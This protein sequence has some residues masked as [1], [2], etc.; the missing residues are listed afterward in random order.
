[1]MVQTEREIQRTVDSVKGQS[2]ILCTIS[3]RES[4]SQ[5]LS[6]FFS[7]KPIRR[8]FCENTKN[9]YSPIFKTIS[10]RNEGVVSEM[11][12]CLVTFLI[13]LCFTLL[14]HSVRW[15]DPL[16]E[17]QFRG[18]LKTGT[19]TLHLISLQTSFYIKPLPGL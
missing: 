6:I 17:G 8:M 19:N 5:H 15:S 7:L 2:H 13:L 4:V 10:N 9:Y 12:H 16:T 18:Q 1:M 3:D 11:T 14:L